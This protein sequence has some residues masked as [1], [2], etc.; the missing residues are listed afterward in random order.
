MARG[1]FLCLFYVCVVCSYFT[2]HAKVELKNNGYEG[3]VVMIKDTVKEDPDL[4]DRIK[5]GIAAEVVVEVVVISF[6]M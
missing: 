3:V 1:G 2:C 6:A 5:V 4:I